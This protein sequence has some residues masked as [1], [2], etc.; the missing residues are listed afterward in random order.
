MKSF[1]NEALKGFQFEKEIVVEDMLFK[2]MGKI[3]L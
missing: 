3:L 1:L 2:F